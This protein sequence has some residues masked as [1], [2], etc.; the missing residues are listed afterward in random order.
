MLNYYLSGAKVIPKTV[1]YVISRLEAD[2]AG[3][4][5]QALK[6]RSNVDA[7]RHAACAAKRQ[8]NAACP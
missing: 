8:T 6:C 1:W 5:K 7:V 2:F 4:P 3:A